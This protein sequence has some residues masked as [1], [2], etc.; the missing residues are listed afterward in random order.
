MNESHREALRRIE[1]GSGH[2]VVLIHGSASDYRTWE[3]QIEAFAGHFHVVTYSRRYHWPNAKISD[4]AEYSMAEQVEDLLRLLRSLGEDA[5][6][7]GHSYGAY[8]ALMAAIREPGL[9][10][11]LVLAEAPVVPL[12]TSFPPKARE[13]LALLV[14]RP[15]TAV[16]IIR[17]AATGLGPATSAA[18]KDDMA[19]AMAYFGRAVLGHE[20]FAALSPARLEQVRENLSKA[21]LLSESFMVPLKE[22]EVAD[23]EARTLLVTGEKSPTFLHRLTDRLEQLMPRAERTE[24]P[25]AS[26]IMHE[27]NPAAFN[28]AVQSFLQR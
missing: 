11:R 27:D 22:R 6:L 5:H 23:I 25:G 8:L 10:A 13:I 12:F 21:E 14:T 9:V 24:I 4:G 7:V 3:H 26:H 18:N 1:R 20:A 2:A 17:F 19:A 16:P 15:R 28:Q